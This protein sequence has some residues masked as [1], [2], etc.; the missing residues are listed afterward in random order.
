MASRPVATLPRPGSFIDW[1]TTARSDVPDEA[2]GPLLGQL[3]VSSTS[4]LIGMLNWVM[5]AVLTLVRR[6]EPAILAVTGAAVIVL[7]IRIAVIHRVD[8]A[9]RAGRPM[10]IEASLWCAMAWCAM[11]GV[12]S[13]VAMTTGDPVL[14]V[15]WTAQILGSLS[16]ITAINFAAPRLAFLLVL[17]CLVPLVAG[18]PFSGYP[19]LLLL[20]PMAPPFLLGV[21][22]I[23]RNFHGLVVDTLVSEWSNARLARHDPL[24][25]LLN[26]HGL[27][28][29][30]K[31]ICTEASERLTILCVDLDGFKLINDTYGHIAGDRLLDEVGAR[32][33]RAVRPA[34]RVA[35]IGGDEFMIVAQGLDPTA[36]QSLAERLVAT[37]SGEPYL[38]DGT[39]VCVG[40][41][42]GYASLP[43][44]AEDIADLWVQADRA[45]YAAKQAR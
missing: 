21:W 43:G 42:A 19:G 15:L 38:I 11:H 14:M 44:D 39:L 2:R 41:S 27:D 31:S 4:V 36:T 34:D 40:A 23:L 22:M 5:V 30:L 6:P 1:L 9:R 17:L 16:A 13:F 25:G 32:L 29:A 7:A 18:T 37:L 28:Q 33:S 3:A 24:T 26:R 8:Q 35:R 12:Q 20:I 45:L 10:Q